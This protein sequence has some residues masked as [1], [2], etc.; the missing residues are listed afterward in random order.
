VRRPF[1]R[2]AALTA[3]ACIVILAVVAIW[4][5]NHPSGDVVFLPNAA[6]D[7]APVVHVRGE[8]PDPR[9]G[10]PG[11]LFV[12]VTIRSASL[13][14]KWF[15]GAEHG[16][17]LVPEEALYPPGQSREQ[18]DRHDVADMTDS[19][20]VA[21][22]VAER[23]LGKPVRIS[24]TGAA[25]ELV[26]AGSPAAAAG[27]RAGDVVV[28]AAG[29]PVTTVAALH[30]ALVRLRPGATIGLRVRRAGQVLAVSSGTRAA[31]GHADQAVIGV[32]VADDGHIDVPI[33]VTY[34]LG[35]VRGPS[36]GLAFALEIYAALTGRTIVGG[37]RIAVT[38]ALA[39]NGAVS[40]IGGV[41]QK[42]IGAGKAHADVFLVPVGED[43]EARRYAPRTVRVMP[44]RSFA[45]A[46]RVLRA[47]PR[48]TGA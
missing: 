47:L 31:P 19:Q 25:V 8:A 24:T 9:P 33:P 44:V 13:L 4:A 43:A 34:R 6:Q 40:P 11:I 22:A 35:D 21:A 29:R 15:V 48:R 17:T 36:A 16:A 1:I 3:A 41:K 37:H 46:L 38:G 7:V 2:G 27:I 32:V 26:Q 18:V 5:V 12:A 28:G 20:R 30:A 23:A 45:D 14:E 39:L 42:A 10:G